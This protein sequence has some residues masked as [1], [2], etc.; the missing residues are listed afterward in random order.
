MKAFFALGALLLIS[1]QIQAK[2][3]PSSESLQ[4]ENTIECDIGDKDMTGGKT[5]TF[6]YIPK[7]SE[8]LCQ[9]GWS[10]TACDYGPILYWDLLGANGEIISS[11]S[12]DYCLKADA[13]N[14]YQLR[15]R[16]PT[17]QNCRLTYIRVKFS[18]Q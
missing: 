14:P 17:A 15:V 7:Q 12:T 6:K 1:F 16:F 18:K 2:C 10:G 4:I 3:L 9:T 11:K 8:F 5:Y 13:G